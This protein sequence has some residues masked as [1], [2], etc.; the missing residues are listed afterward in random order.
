[1][2]KA[3]HSQPLNIYP[4][5]IWVTGLTYAWLRESACS[6]EALELVKKEDLQKTSMWAV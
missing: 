5:N 3:A 1:M 4:T 6:Q 2:I